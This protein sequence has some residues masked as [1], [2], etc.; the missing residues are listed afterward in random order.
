[1]NNTNLREYGDVENIKNDLKTLNEILGRQGQNLFIDVL[2]EAI[3]NACATYRLNEMER[4]TLLQN[5][6]IDLRTAIL[7]RI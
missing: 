2:A 1:M 7:E 6:E 3:G 4:Q 5:A